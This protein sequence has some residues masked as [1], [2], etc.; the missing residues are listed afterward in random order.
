M[1]INI[2]MDDE[3]MKRLDNYADRTY[4]SRS[5]FISLAVTQYLN[6]NEMLVAI[7]DMSLALRKIADN[8]V[9]DDETYKSI[10]DMER[11]CKMFS[12]TL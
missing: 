5:G 8:G 10:E 6:T 11:V 3:L 2:T 9:L 12:N 1:K 4:M 7:K